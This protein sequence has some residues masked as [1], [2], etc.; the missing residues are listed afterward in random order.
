MLGERL[1]VIFA[2]AAVPPCSAIKLQAVRDRLHRA[3]V[4]ARAGAWGQTT[5]ARQRSR[6]EVF[7]LATRR[8]HRSSSCRRTT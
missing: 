2:F 6:K 4:C 1:H 3:L 5:R 8:F 7:I